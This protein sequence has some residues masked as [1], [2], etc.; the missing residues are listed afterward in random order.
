MKISG[1]SGTNLNDYKFSDLSYTADMVMTRY[2]FPECGSLY[3]KCQGVATHT[4]GVEAYT[5]SATAYT[6][7][8][9]A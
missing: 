9:A 7:C 2:T 5:Q 1:G 4:H 6:Q 3:S 8:S